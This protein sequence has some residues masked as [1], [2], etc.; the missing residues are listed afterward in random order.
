[1]EWVFNQISMWKNLPDSTKKFANLA[2]LYQIL[3]NNMA[4]LKTKQILG[5]EFEDGNY[6]PDTAAQ[7][8]EKQQKYYRKK[9]FNHRSSNPTGQ[10]MELQSRYLNILED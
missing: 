3:T 10:F 9:F 6:N 5:G 1:M 8:Y 4:I 2:Q 7:F